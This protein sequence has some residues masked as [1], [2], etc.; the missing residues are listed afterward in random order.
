MIQERWTVL[1]PW[2]VYSTRLELQMQNSGLRKSL[3]EFWYV[4]NQAQHEKRYDKTNISSFRSA[5]IEQ[6]K[7]IN[8]YMQLIIEPTAVN[9]ANW[10]SRNSF[11]PLRKRGDSS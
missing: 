11:T 9:L 3:N 1:Y 7:R 6:F 10:Q 2:A 8:I 5:S 4:I